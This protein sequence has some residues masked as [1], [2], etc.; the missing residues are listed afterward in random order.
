MNDLLCY[1]K[2]TDRGLWPVPEKESAQALSRWA[3]GQKAGTAIIMRVL[4]KLNTRRDVHHALYRLRN[5]IL[6]PA[7]DTDVDSLHDWIKAELDMIEENEIAGK[8]HKR[9]RSQKE[10]TSEEMNAMFAKQD[11]LRDF[12]NLDREPEHYLILPE[13]E[14]AN[15]KRE[16]A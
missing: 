10:F 8:T 2:E 4:K 1:I 7:L 3:G 11:E 6:A 5:A 12:V 16:P 14:N 15:E 9:L 13:G